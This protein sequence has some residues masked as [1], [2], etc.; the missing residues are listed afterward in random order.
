MQRE[1]PLACRLRLVASALSRFLFALLGLAFF[2]FL[3]LPFRVDFWRRI[4]ERFGFGTRKP[5]DEP[6]QINRE[7]DGTERAK[8]Y[9]EVFHVQ[10]S[11]S[12]FLSPHFPPVLNAA[13][14]SG[15]TITVGHIHPPCS[16]WALT[17]MT[18]P[19]TIAING[20]ETYRWSL[21]TAEK[22]ATAAK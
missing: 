1:Q 16:F 22:N 11:R 4:G 10:S 15:T 8:P 20:T 12:F 19:P 3:L 17:K 21:M 9:A 2:Q 6:P 7:D 13:M 14:R 5:H 18:S